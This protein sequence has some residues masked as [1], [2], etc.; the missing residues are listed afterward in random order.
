MKG[1]V[2]ELSRMIE[3]NRKYRYL[4]IVHPFFPKGLERIV[5]RYLPHEILIAISQ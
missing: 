2:E 4:I 5:Q 1:H 3:R